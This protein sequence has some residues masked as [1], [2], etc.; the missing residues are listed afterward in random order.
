VK[1]YID[2]ELHG[3]LYAEYWIAESIAATN[4]EDDSEWTY[5][6]EA[7]PSNVH[8]G[9]AYRVAVYDEEGELLGY[10]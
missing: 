5:R 6:A 1:P 4:A 7:A 10:L 9:V 2:A 8:P 3:T